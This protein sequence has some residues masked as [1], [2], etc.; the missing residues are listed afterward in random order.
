MLGLTSFTEVPFVVEFLIAL[1][2]LG[3][4]IDYSLLVVTRWREERDRGAATENA[5]VAAVKTAG[6][7]VLDGFN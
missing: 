6:H 7:A 4:A 1:V 2:G 5:I 3:I